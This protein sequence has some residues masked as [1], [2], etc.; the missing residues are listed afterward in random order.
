M[1]G[2]A[3][4]ASCTFLT[5]MP[6]FAATVTGTVD[7]PAVGDVPFVERAPLRELL[8]A[9]DEVVQDD[10]LD[11]AVLTGGGNGAADE[12]GAAGDENL[13]ASTFVRGLITARSRGA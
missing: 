1:Y 2:C 4:P 12:A 10:R 5:V 11:P 6:A 13:H 9:G 7:E 3:A 8:A